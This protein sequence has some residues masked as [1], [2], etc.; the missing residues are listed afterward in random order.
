MTG[1]GPFPVTTTSGRNRLR[2]SHLG[3][4]RRPVRSKPTHSLSHQR[5]F[6]GLIQTQLELDDYHLGK[7]TKNQQP[8]ETLDAA[9]SRLLVDTLDDGPGADARAQIRGWA[10]EYAAALTD[11]AD[12]AAAAWAEA[13]EWFAKRTKGGSLSM[14]VHQEFA[15]RFGVDPYATGS[16]S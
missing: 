9:A 4:R 12:P 11:S 13:L 16:S 8:G 6:T 15:A 7:L 3:R 5:C 14:L 2:R 1:N 10:E